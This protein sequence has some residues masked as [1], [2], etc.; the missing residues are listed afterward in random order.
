MKKIFSILVA[1]SLFAC[2]EKSNNDYVTIKGTI[3]N[4][5]NN[6]L[7]ILG[8]NFK[9]EITVNEDGT[10]KD[11]L[12]V[13]QGFHG[14]NDGKQQSFIYLKNGYDLEL[15]FD[16][17]NFQESI[18]FMGE[19]SKTNNYLGKKIQLIKDEQLDKYQLIFQMDQADF[20][21]RITEIKQKTG[22][23]LSQAKGVE[24]E[25]VDMET[26][27][28][29]ELID[30]LVSNYNK[31]HMVQAALKKGA[32][33]PTFNYP[34]NNGNSVSLE[35]LKGKYVYI[36]VW[37]TWCGPCKGEIP[38]L[39]EI[40]DEFKGKDI[41]FVSLSIDKMEHKEKWLKMIQDEKLQ[42]IQVLADKDWNS[43][44]V[45]AY[46][47]KGIPRFILLDKNGNIVD[48]NAPRPSDPGLKGLL[49]SLEL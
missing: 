18:E 42:G 34:D 47:I 37:A 46:N 27:A 4:A 45:T 31:E 43:D 44:F 40:D 5:D 15:N 16:A 14:F 28:N 33:S 41:A 22:D 26:K 11:T 39:K 29:K 12:K 20:D 19:G 8:K 23:L 35:D 48:A 24:Q 36:D 7:S 38:Y 32:P 1:L 6:T 49:N 13:L 17:S 9:K 3:A 25:V 10:Y 30:F 2:S 21:N